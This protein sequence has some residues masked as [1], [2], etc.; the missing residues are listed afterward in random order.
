MKKVV[1]KCSVWC[2]NTPNSNTN[3]PTGTRK[4]IKYLDNI[5]LTQ[6]LKEARINV[7]S[8]FRLKLGAVYEKPTDMIG[9]TKETCFVGVRKLTK[10]LMLKKYK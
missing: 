5:H 2:I 7:E 8:F 1:Q 6:Y 9:K 3:T 4:C 10:S